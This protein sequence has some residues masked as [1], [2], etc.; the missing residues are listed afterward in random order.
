MPTT[1]LLRATLN[2]RPMLMLWCAYMIGFAYER[3]VGVAHFV[4]GT[5]TAV[6]NQ[7]SQ[8]ACRG[9]MLIVRGIYPLKQ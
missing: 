5:T 8:A 2:P 9:R 3:A 4:W 1:L 7:E 6:R